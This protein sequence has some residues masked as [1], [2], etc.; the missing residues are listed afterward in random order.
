M[1]T[2]FFLSRCNFSSI[3]S[4]KI[5]Q[6]CLLWKVKRNWMKCLKLHVIEVNLCSIPGC[7]PKEECGSVQRVS[8]WKRK[9][10]I[11]KEGGNVKKVM[12]SIA[13]LYS[14]A[15]VVPSLYFQNFSLQNLHSIHS[16]SF[17]LSVPWNLSPS[18]SKPIFAYCILKVQCYS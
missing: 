4:D 15:H 17:C 18:E 10:P 16:A 5:E 12:I 8:I 11:Q 2:R 14:L 1:F 7:F 13:T 3:V 6:I 9:W